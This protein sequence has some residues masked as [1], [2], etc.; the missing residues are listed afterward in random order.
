MTATFKFTGLVLDDAKQ[1]VK[2]KVLSLSADPAVTQDSTTNENYIVAPKLMTD[3]NGFICL[4]V[5][6]G[7]K[8]VP[9][10]TPGVDLVKGVQY[11]IW[12]QNLPRTKFDP[13]AGSTLDLADLPLN[14]APPPVTTWASVLAGALAPLVAANAALTA[15]VADLTARLVDLETQAATPFVE[16]PSG[17]ALYASLALTEAPDGSGLYDVLGLTEDTANPGLYLIGA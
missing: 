1:P 5:R 4:V 3:D 17:S 2:R 8:S 16:D 6:V 14:V 12:G 10:D 9:A 7:N 13:P 15:T 11:T